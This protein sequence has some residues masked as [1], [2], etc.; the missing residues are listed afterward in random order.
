MASEKD[1]SIY[2]DRGTIGSADELDEYG[3]WVK[4]EPQDLSAVSTDS[5]DS[6]EFSIPDIEDLPDFDSESGTEDYSFSLAEDGGQDQ[7]D[8]LDI[9][10]MDPLPEPDSFDESAVSALAVKKDIADEKGFT[11]VS[12]DDFLGDISED[13]ED[14]DLDGGVFQEADDLGEI[15]EI[16]EEELPEFEDSAAPGETGG[17]GEA[18]LSQAVKN[19]D[20]S[21]QLLM[22]IA[23][24]LASIKKELSSLKS[25]L[26]GMRGG[27]SA[28]PAEA[29]EGG[30][31][32]DED[33]DEKIALTG[34]EL[35]NI[36]NTADFTEEAG[37][38]ATEELPGLGGG[39]PAFSSEALT[40]PAREDLLS[41]RED[42]IDDQELRINLDEPELDEIGGETGLDQSSNFTALDPSAF[43]VSLD[44]A[45]DEAV[46]TETAADNAGADD[47]PEGGAAESLDDADD[48]IS[49]EEISLDDFPVEEVE[50]KD[51]EELKELREK[52]VEPMTPPPEDTSYLDES[53]LAEED[54][55]L[56]N[57]VIDEPDLSGIQENPLTEPSLDDISLDLDL[58]EESGKADE[59]VSNDIVYEEEETMELSMPEVGP[60]EIISDSFDISVEEPGEESFEQVIPEGFVVEADSQMPAMEQEEPAEAEFEVIEE[61]AEEAPAV[62]EVPSETA[63]QPDLPVNLKQELKT[64]L[65]YMDQLLE[66]LP[67]D[68][69]EEFAKSKYFD[70]YKK[71]FEELGLV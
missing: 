61:K 27:G 60:T 43:D 69:I 47:V 37:S 15:G 55:D 11:E 35:D 8:D 65:S 68:K 3:V 21:T 51:S 50:S 57:A 54:L 28:A 24:E 64:V 2:Y 53:P 13:L 71:L 42:I 23:D 5:Q 58:E 45:G 14:P 10:E 49:F 9:P 17:A 40:A 39:E 62:P 7:E 25:E 66:S 67:E 41:D 52:G 4:S 70:T 44:D 12:M 22:K 31:F 34:D 36:L 16:S 56:T 63:E 59:D 6:G 18:S 1:P 20:L 26:S 32:F 29:D 38:D 33:V 48:T 19:A 46:E 30:G